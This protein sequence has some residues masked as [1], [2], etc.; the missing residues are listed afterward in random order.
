[1]SWG[2]WLCRG[3]SLV[4]W[5]PQRLRGPSR[6][7]RKL[8]DWDRQRQGEADRQIN[9]HVDLSWPDSFEKQRRI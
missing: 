3:P 1:M 5:R 6:K 4:D 9:K 8:R 2:T 7:K